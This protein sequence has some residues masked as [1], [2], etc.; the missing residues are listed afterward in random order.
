MF[1]AS[2]TRLYTLAENIMHR[3]V[4]EIQG[5]SIEVELYIIYYIQEGISICLPTTWVAHIEE[6]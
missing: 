3:E 5:F 1:G 4:N 6:G 2:S